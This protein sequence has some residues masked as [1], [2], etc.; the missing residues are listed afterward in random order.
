[1]QRWTSTGLSKSAERRTRGPSP[2]HHINVHASQEAI[3]IITNE[4]W[5]NPFGVNSGR[6]WKADTRKAGVGRLMLSLRLP[7]IYP[8]K[9]CGYESMIR[10]RQFRCSNQTSGLPYSGQDWLMG[11]E[12]TISGLPPPLLLLPRSESRISATLYGCAVAFFIFHFGAVLNI[13]RTP[14]PS[15]P[16]PSVAVAYI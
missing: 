7:R 5:L 10:I 6:L 12:G 13:L 14:I 2:H 15:L 1:M 4:V 11:E 8:P 16:L 3:Q 9:R